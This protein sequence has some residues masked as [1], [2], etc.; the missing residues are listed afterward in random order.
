MAMS[1]YTSAFSARLALALAVE[2]ADQ[3][4]HHAEVDRVAGGGAPCGDVPSWKS[5]R[6]V[7]ASPITPSKRDDLK[8]GVV[9]DAPQTLAG[10]APVVDRIAVV[11][12][13][14]VRRQ[15]QLAA[16]PQHPCALVEVDVGFRRRA[17]APGSRRPRRRSRRPAAACRRARSRRARQG[18]PVGLRRDSRRR[19]RT[20][21]RYL[22]RRSRSRRRASRVAGRVADE[23]RKRSSCKRAG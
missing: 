10:P 23:R 19:R 12:H 13:D 22:C 18:C 3:R 14:P 16:G 6:P 5:W 8:P 4:L 15:Q 9:H 7:A 20:G 2:R 21:R 17:R 11:H 1:A